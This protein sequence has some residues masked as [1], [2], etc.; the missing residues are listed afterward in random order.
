MYESL[1]CII[2]FSPEYR[3][4]HTGLEAVAVDNRHTHSTHACTHIRTHAHTKGREDCGKISKIVRS[5]CW[6]FNAMS[7][8]RAI[9]MAKQDC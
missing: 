6:K 8:T 2:T 4:T 5:E 1:Q 9:F 7:A 3:H